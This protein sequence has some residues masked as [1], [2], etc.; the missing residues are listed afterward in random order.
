MMEKHGEI[1]DDITP[2]EDGFPEPPPKPRSPDEEIRKFAG[3]V[4]KAQ[5]KAELLREH[6]ASRSHTRVQD[7]LK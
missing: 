2:P 3:L 1:R 6:M 5:K 4:K 7:R